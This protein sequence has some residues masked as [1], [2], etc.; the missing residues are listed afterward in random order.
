MKTEDLNFFRSWFY[1]YVKPYYTGDDYIEKNLKLKEKHIY[2]VCKSIVM[3]GKE[4]NLNKHQLQLAETIALFHDIGR[5]E[6]LKKYKTLNDRCSANHA[7]L[8][9][10]VLKETGVIKRLSEEEQSFI[11]KSIRYHN[12][13]KLPENESPDCLLYTKLLR[14][15]DKI[16]IWFIVTEYYEKR[17]LHPNAALEFD[18]P[19]TPEY[20]PKVVGDIMNCR[21][22]SRDNIKTYSDMKLFNLSWIF[23]IN[24][25]PTFRYIQKHKYIDKTIDTFPDTADIRKV[26]NHLNKYVEKKVMTKN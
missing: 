18:L 5:F 4:L 12:A 23:D 8:S 2:G 3:I 10:E 24:F 21:C 16:N 15:A 25:L 22:A 1:S 13:Y 19:D 7:E 14:D 26:R 20:S 6:Q 11:L 9:I 17:Q